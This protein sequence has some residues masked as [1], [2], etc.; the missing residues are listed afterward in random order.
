[1]RV[2]RAWFCIITASIAGGVVRKR[3]SVMIEFYMIR[4]FR[5]LSLW[6]IDGAANRLLNAWLHYLTFVL[7][8]VCLQEENSVQQLIEACIQEED[9]L[10]LCVSS[11]TIKVTFRNQAADVTTWFNCVLSLTG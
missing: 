9:K 6:M 11:P 3:R 10:Y 5:S 4:L 2:M 7:F 8:S 1:M